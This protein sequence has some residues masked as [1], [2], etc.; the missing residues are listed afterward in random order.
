MINRPRLLLAED[1]EFAAEIMVKFLNEQGFETTAVFTA[2]DAIAKVKNE[3]Y[4]LLILDINLPDFDGYEVLKS[5]KNS[6]NL[7]IIMTS[8][9]S[10]TQ[11]KLISFKY[12]AADYMVKPIDLEEL[13]ARIWL[14]LSKSSE[15]KITHQQMLFRV[16]DHQIIYGDI[17]LDL[18]RTEFNILSL[19]IQHSNHV[20]KRETLLSALSNISTGRSLDNHI[21]NIRKKIDD[22]GN[23]ARILTTEYAIG[24]RLHNPLRN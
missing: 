22:D 1:D 8:A 13:E 14:Q 18:T 19:L 20:V 17:I 23:K 3:H 10:D 15:I 24:Y 11:S 5:L 12:G 9:Y 7:P 21:K 2:T 6:V 16:D 4:N